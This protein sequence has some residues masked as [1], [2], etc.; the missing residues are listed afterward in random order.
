MNVKKFFY[1]FVSLSSFCLFSNVTAAKQ[2][3]L[4][5]V[6]YPDTSQTTESQDFAPSS[7]MQNIQL[8]NYLSKNWPFGKAS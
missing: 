5:T 3:L 6:A 4:K 7:E 1:L 2:K 8:T